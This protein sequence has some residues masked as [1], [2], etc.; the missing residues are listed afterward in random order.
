M[1]DDDDDDDDW[2][3]TNKLKFTNRNNKYILMTYKRKD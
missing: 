1:P 3:K 2:L